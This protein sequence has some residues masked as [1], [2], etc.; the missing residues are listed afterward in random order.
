M[1]TRFPVRIDLRSEGRR[2]TLHA[3]AA[4]T[5]R[6]AV[7]QP[8]AT[9]MEL[10]ATATITRRSRLGVPRFLPSSV[11]VHYRW[12]F[13]VSDQYLHNEF[14]P[15]YDGLLRIRQSFKLFAVLSQ[16]PVRRRTV[17]SQKVKLL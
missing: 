14:D 9:Y 12:F 10:T 3:T 17:N 7:C 16:N 11:E 15:V 4:F 1:H 6:A 5:A 8:A 13:G 2:D